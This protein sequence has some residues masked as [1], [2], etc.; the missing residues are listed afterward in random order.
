MRVV[1][2]HVDHPHAHQR[3]EPDRAAGV[4]GEHEE[5]AAVGD[6]AAV[7][8]DAVH[9]RRHAELAHAV[10]HVAAR[11][12]ARPAASCMPLRD[13]QVRVRQVGR[14]AERRLDRRVDHLQRHF[15]T[16]CA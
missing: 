16:L 7:Q 3:R 2:H 1:R 13:R 4:V 14:A 15:A 8:R 6:E 9:R 5:R 12:I 11:E 10:A